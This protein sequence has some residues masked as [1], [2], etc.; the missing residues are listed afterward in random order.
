MKK[1]IFYVSNL[2]A[3]VGIGACNGI[4]MNNMDKK[5]PISKDAN[6]SSGIFSSSGSNIGFSRTSIIKTEPGPSSESNIDKDAQEV[7]LRKRVVSLLNEEVKRKLGAE[8]P[9]SYRDFLSN[10]GSTKLKNLS[11]GPFSIV[12]FPTPKT[13]SDEDIKKVVRQIFFE[14]RGYTSRYNLVMSLREA[15]V[16]SKSKDIKPWCIALKH[17]EDDSISGSV[18]YYHIDLSNSDDNRCIYE[19]KDNGDIH[20]IFA[21]DITDFIEKCEKESKNSELFYKSRDKKRRDS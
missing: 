11:I 6:E 2:L 8:L 12:S 13:G 20:G 3:C 21:N 15:S 4:N 19:E 16:S 5:K 9:E 17:Q 10:N 14:Q 1:N 7:K 18:L